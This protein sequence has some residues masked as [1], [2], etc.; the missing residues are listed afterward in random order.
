MHVSFEKKLPP[1]PE[2]I[3]HKREET[4]DIFAQTP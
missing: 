4:D 3:L 1:K 2:N